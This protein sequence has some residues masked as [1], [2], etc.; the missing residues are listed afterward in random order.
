MTQRQL[1]ENVIIL[2]LII[3]DL[4]NIFLLLFLLFFEPTSTKPQ[5][6]KLG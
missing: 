1:A 5:A 2:L 3:I 4:K 6:G